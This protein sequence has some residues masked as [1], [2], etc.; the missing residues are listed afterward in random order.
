MVAIPAAP[1][2]L[3]LALM[4]GAECLELA[5]ILAPPVWHLDAACRE[6]PETNFFP[7]RGQSTAPAQR[8][9]ARCLVRAE[10]LVYA[11]ERR[12]SDLVGIW[13]GTSE[14]QRREARRRKWSTGD[15]LDA[16]EKYSQPAV[17]DDVCAEC[18]SELSGH[19]LVRGD[20]YCFGCRPA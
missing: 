7:G 9:C 6:H 2:P 11:Y 13:G 10:C 3:Y 20:G 4:T 16:L 1:D 14:H 8:V 15:L 12:P 17:V 5:E 19:D 18:H